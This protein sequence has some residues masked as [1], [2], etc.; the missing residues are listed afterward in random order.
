MNLILESFVVI[1]AIL[2]ERKSIDVTFLPLENLFLLF[3]HWMTFKDLSLFYVESY[4][5]TSPLTKPT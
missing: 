3:L 2:T 1:M 5:I 4:I